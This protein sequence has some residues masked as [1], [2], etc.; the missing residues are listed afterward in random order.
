MNKDAH[1]LGNMIDLAT[2][3]LP[4]PPG[5]SDYLDFM[6]SAV[7]AIADGLD[8]IANLNGE[9]YS[10]QM[11]NCTGDEFDYLLEEF[12]LKLDLTDAYNKRL[13]QLRE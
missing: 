12:L 9:R 1:F 10:N 4:I 7:G 11:I 5:V 13:N 6:G 8:Q 3:V 2:G